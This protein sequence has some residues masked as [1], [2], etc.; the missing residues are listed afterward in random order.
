MCAYELSV[1]DGGNLGPVF[2][3]AVSS[4]AHL[5]DAVGACFGIRVEAHFEFISESG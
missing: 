1:R 4:Q 3:V 2:V 5:D